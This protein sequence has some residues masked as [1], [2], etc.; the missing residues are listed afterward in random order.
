MAL[1]GAVAVVYGSA[2]GISTNGNQLFTEN[3]PGVPDKAEVPDLFGP[4]VSAQMTYYETP[5]GAKV[6]AAGTLDFVGSCLTW[7]VTRMLRNLWDHLS[8]P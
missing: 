8:H 3:S 1:G 5:D 6:F 2:A 4:G 7:P